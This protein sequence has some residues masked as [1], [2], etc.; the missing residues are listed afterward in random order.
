M[1]DM[2]SCFCYCVTEIIFWTVIN[3]VGYKGGGVD[4]LARE[5]GE[6]H[7]DVVGVGEGE[8]VG[9]EEPRVCHFVLFSLMYLMVMAASKPV[10]LVDIKARLLDHMMERPMSPV[11]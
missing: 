2:N 10:D 7:V 5:H 11:L 9:G 8:G 4:S 6:G 1:D 3:H